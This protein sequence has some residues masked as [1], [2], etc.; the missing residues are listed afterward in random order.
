MKPECCK[1][2]VIDIAIIGAGIHGC[3]IAA[4]AASRGLST[5]VIEAEDIASGASS[6]SHRIIGGD[7]AQLERLDIDAVNRGLQEQAILRKRAPHLVRSHIFT[8]LPNTAL[9]SRLRV[10]LG[11]NSYRALQR[12]HKLPNTSQPAQLTNLA[13]ADLQSYCDDS[14]DDSRLTVALAQQASQLGAN[15]HTQCQLLKAKRN[16]TA[17]HWE[18][19]LKDNSDKHL[20]LHCKTLINSAGAA[21]NQLMTDSIEHSS[22]SKGLLVR[23]DYLIMPCADKAGHSLLLQADNKQLVYLLDY[24]CG[25][26]CVLGPWQTP[27]KNNLDND[28]IKENAK[29]K[30]LKLYN[31]NINEPL[32]ASDVYKSFYTTRCLCEDSSCEKI[33]TSTDYCLDLDN[34]AAQPALLTIY[35]GNISTHRLLAEQALNILQP[36]TH[37]AINTD[38]K[39]HALPGGDF[40]EGSLSAL[41][42]ELQFNYP[43][44]DT[45]LLHRLAQSYG[46]NSY[47]ILADIKKPAELGQHFGAHLYQREV[48]YLCSNEWAKTADDILWR[49]SK[50]G[51]RFTPEQIETLG[52]FMRSITR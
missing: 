37:A 33:N 41:I 3:A 19:K 49:R 10:K 50:L 31:R 35:G 45:G 36:F 48:E 11:L 25:D 12:H 6:H 44:L 28:A 26:Y 7:L 34:P 38:F 13:T 17:Q 40:P 21:I 2:E 29:N 1:S 30:L 42:D 52:N 14:V 23:D 18:L 32:T 16:K 9:R 5:T 46:S 47:K 22:R 8:L 39:T 43:K 27:L 20:T 15:I 24:P 4:E 51:L